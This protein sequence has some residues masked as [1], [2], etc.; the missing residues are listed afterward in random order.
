M[1]RVKISSSQTSF[2]KLPP[3]PKVDD[4]PNKSDVFKASERSEIMRKVRSTHNKSTELR[5]IE[6][7]KKRRL[8]GWR[9]NVRLFGHPDFVFPKLRIAVFVDGCFWH[10][11]SCRNT[12]PKDHADYW[13]IKINRNQIR[14]R[15]VTEHLTSL[16]YLVIRIW[17]CEFKRANVARLEEKLRPLIEA[18]RKFEKPMP[19][20]SD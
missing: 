2:P 8:I 14:D 15:V 17:E 12:T 20:Q 4:S 10:G 18:S 11:H 1:S 7:F 3:V 13:R 6:E 16:G 5:L 9:R 19:K